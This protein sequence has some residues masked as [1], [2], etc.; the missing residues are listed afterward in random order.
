MFCE[1]LFFVE[2]LFCEKVSFGEAAPLE[3]H[4]ITSMPPLRRRPPFAHVLRT[5][6]TQSKPLDQGLMIVII[7]S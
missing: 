3:E 4:H 5:K 7:V 2:K 1:K 6:T